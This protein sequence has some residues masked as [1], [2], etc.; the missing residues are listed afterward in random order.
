MSENNKKTPE[1]K[2]EPRPESRP[3]PVTER[4]DYNEKS[5]RQPFVNEGTGPRDP[6]KSDKE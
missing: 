6:Q 5:E 3:Q 4:R 1:S 2:P